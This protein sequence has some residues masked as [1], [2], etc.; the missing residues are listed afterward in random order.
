MFR[1]YI[2]AFV[3]VVSLIALVTTGQ[4][5]WIIAFLAWLPPLIEGIEYNK[6][7]MNSSASFWKD[8]GYDN[9][10]S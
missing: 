9:D 2:P 10:Q 1:V 6:S 5:I 7:L 4:L 8:R 3:M